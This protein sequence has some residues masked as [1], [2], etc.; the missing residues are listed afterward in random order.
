MSSGNER[1]GY[2]AGSQ[3][4]EP[5]NPSSEYA[6]VQGNMRGAQSTAADEAEAGVKVCSFYHTQDVETM[7]TICDSLYQDPRMSLP[8]SLALK[9][10]LDSEE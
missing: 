3:T 10:I 6:E 9:L 8:L 4:E 5:Y 2:Q 1:Y 7:P